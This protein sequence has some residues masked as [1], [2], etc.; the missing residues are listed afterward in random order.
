MPILTFKLNLAVTSET[1]Y[2][3]HG[4]DNELPIMHPIFFGYGPRIR[5]RTTVEPFDTVDLY[6]LFCELLGLDAPYY[7]DG[8]REHI[9]AV[10]RNDSRDDD[11]DD[12][13]GTSARTVTLMGKAKQ[14]FTKSSNLPKFKGNINVKA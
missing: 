2:G 14:E 7:L 10:L 5:E 8:K 4:Y 1:K 9:V 11:D 12:P 3:V 6:Y 13:S